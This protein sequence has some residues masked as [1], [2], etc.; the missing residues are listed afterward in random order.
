MLSQE[1]SL[2]RVRIKNQIS[3]EDRKVFSDF[4]ITNHE[5]LIVPQVLKILEALQNS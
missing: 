3:D 2:K 4:I 5:K 1:I